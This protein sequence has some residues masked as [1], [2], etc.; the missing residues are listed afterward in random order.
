MDTDDTNSLTGIRQQ[1]DR[2]DED[3]HRLLIERSS[4]ID[5]LIRIKGTSAPGAAFRPDREA[6][7]MRRI[8]RRHEGRL[9]L[10]TVEHIW[11]EIITVFTAMQAPFSVVAGPSDDPAAHRDIIRFYFGFSI[12]VETADS[13][14]AALAMVSQSRNKIAALAFRAETPW[15]RKLEGDSGAK[16]FARYPFLLP[17]G[18][19]SLPPVYIAGPP[20]K[21]QMRPDICL[22]SLEVKN[23]ITD[24]ALAELGGRITLRKNRDYL[25]EIPEDVMAGDLC[26]LLQAAGV[27]V[28][29]LEQVGGFARPIEIFSPGSAGAHGEGA[30]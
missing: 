16:V 4:V 6:D 14:E 11:R 17:G 24:V 19:V 1:I 12:Q 22:F 27:G 20:V 10:S 26:G 29:S 18:A 15:W 3:I 9:P 8:V 28:V 7:M 13:E 5:E 21:D 23:E 2:L 30:V 25:V